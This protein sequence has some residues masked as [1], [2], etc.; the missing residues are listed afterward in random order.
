MNFS[1]VLKLFV[2]S[3]SRFVI[4][5]VISYSI[6]IN[7]TTFQYY[8]LIK[9]LA[10][11]NSL[12]RKKSPR[13]HWRYQWIGIDATNVR[14]KGLVVTLEDDVHTVHDHVG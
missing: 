2:C 1:A 3:Y 12:P 13:Q 14:Y 8:S 6:A 10:K 5:V 11:N 9:P 7:L 4:H